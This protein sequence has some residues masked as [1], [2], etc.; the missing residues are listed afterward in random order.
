MKTLR[1]SEDLKL[2]EDA[3]EDVTAIVGRRGRG[4]TNTA[5]VL[6]EE[7]H[8]L[9][10]RF[11]VVDPVGVWHGLRS[12]RDGRAPG[13]PCVVMG[14]EHPMVP[15][16]PTSGKVVADFVAQPGPSVVL[17]FRLMRKGEASRFMTDFLER[18]YLKNRE[19]L[20]LVVDEADKVAPQRPF[21]EEARMLGA[22][23]DV[24][25]MGRA[26]GLHTVLITQRPATLSKNVLTQ[27]GVLIAH[28]L[29]GP[30]DQKAIDA[31]I[32][33]R[34]DEE[35]RA[36]FLAT[37]GGL[38]R[39]EA[40]VWA[41]E[42]ELFKRARIRARETFDS[43]ATPKRGE[44]RAAPKVFAEVDLERLSEE[45]K[46]TAERAKAEDPKELK[47]Q[48][49]DLGAKLKRSQ[50]DHAD[51][52]SRLARQDSPGVKTRDVPVLKDAQVKRLEVA[53]ER[54]LAETARMGDVLA[55]R[56][57]T[58]VSEAGLLRSEI[59]A[60]LAAQGIR[61]ALGRSPQWDSAV[62]GGGSGQSSG[63]AAPRPA[64]VVPR[65]P[66]ANAE[67]NGADVAPARQRILDALAW[68]ESVRIAQANRTQLAML[69]DQ[70]PTSSAYQNNLGALRTLG[71]IDYGAGSTVFLTAAGRR[72]AA[73]PEEPP[74]SDALQASILRRLPPAKQ[75]ILQQLIRVY[76]RGFARDALADLSSASATSSA[77]QNNLGSL[78]SLG[79]I[80]YRG[81]EV[82]A[83]PV[84]F[85]EG[86]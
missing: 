9:G 23:E 83:R 61:D 40:W 22:A 73:M 26:R 80:E 54:L 85:L 20:L 74:S 32:R 43:S 16:E 62:S 66:R 35:R 5:T 78:R 68:L 18:L 10:M 64:P 51:A 65:A 50:A 44:R 24:V 11:C 6:V 29:P 69:A 75:R 70:S 81:G 52:L 55:Q 1:I 46:A 38:D 4:K 31:W 12:S 77:Y 34:A 72:R 79:V 53:V 63:G 27:A 76:P 58:V 60:S 36:E 42:R 37:L 3:L 59:K 2:P 82:F 39:G 45:I 30:Q 28:A 7:A 21:G 15:L 86:A 19:S 8:R 47:R 57:Q 71:L 84:L 56:Q 17:D 25:K 14:G 49:A 67:G 48:L 41:P 13:I 33:E